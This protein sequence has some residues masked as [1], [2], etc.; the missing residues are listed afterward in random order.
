MRTNK[1][2]TTAKSPKNDVNKYP[3]RTGLGSPKSTLP[4]SPKN[5]DTKS[6]ISINSESRLGKWKSE[7]NM[8]MQNS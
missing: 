6:K 5:S 3:N 8:R 1:N 7:K 4:Y 2:I